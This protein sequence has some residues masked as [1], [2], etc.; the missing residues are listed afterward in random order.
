MPLKLYLSYKPKG[1]VGPVHPGC[2]LQSDVELGSIA[3][4]TL[5]CHSQRAPFSVGHNKVLI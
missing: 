3:V 2:W 5:I 1:N 4:R